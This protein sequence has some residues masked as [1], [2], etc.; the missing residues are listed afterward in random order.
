MARQKYDSQ[1]KEVRLINAYAVLVV[2]VLHTIRGIGFLAMTWS[3]VVLLGGFVSMLDRKDFW[4][5][6]LITAVELA[7]LVFL[8]S[9]FMHLYCLL[10][11]GL[12]W[13]VDFCL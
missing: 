10:H 8:S 4:R 13:F 2:Y 12:S 3:T 1:W 6:T 9:H 7:W 11:S 5:L